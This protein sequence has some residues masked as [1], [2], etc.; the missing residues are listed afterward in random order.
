MT[1]KLLISRFAEYEI[2]SKCDGH[3][4]LTYFLT[5]P[6]YSNNSTCSATSHQTFHSKLSLSAQHLP[7]AIRLVPI[8]D[9][10]LRG[11]QPGRPSASNGDRAVIFRRAVKGSEII[12]SS[13]CKRDRAGGGGSR[14]DASTVGSFHRAKDLREVPL[15]L[16]LHCLCFRLRRTTAAQGVRFTTHFHGGPRR[17]CNKCTWDVRLPCGKTPR[18]SI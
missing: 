10:L 12:R 3:L 1:F 15:R 16:A 4:I 18:T 6:Q 17:P 11:L 7:S 9:K 14:V 13:Q 8:T 5:Q 2:S